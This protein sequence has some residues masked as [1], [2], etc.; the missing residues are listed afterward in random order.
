MVLKAVVAIALL[1]TLAA[2]MMRT[3]RGADPVCAQIRQHDPNTLRMAVA[4]WHMLPTE[5]TRYF[6][7]ARQFRAKV[8]SCGRA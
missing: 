3:A 6:K 4:N 2:C 8:K 5:I 1:T 7:S